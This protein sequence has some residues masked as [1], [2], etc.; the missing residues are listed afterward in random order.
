MKLIAWRNDGTPKLRQLRQEWDKIRSGQQP[1]TPREWS[2]AIG[3]GV[4][5]MTLVMLLRWAF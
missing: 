5:V 3:V 4:V 1:L 2:W